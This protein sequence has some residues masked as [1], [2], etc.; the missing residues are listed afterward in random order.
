ML[1]RKKR[2][3]KSYEISQSVQSFLSPEYQQINVARL[4]HLQSLGFNFSGKNVLE[5]GAGIGDHTL[6]YLINNS[7]I[8][9]VEG[10]EELVDYISRRFNIDV[11]LQ[12]LE[13]DFVSKLKRPYLYDIAHCYGILYHLSDPEKFIRSV[14]TLANCLILETCVSLDG[15]EVNLVKE[16]RNESTQAINGTGCRPNR[17]WI[18]NKIME[19][20][21]YAY[22]PITQ[23]KHVQFPKIFKNVNQTSQAGSRNIRAI[24]I[25]SNSPVELKKLSENLVSEYHD[26]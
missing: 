21:E 11:V 25:G 17:K 18:F 8:T 5:L 20:F 3:K 14:A 15:D 1:F 19:N 10:R 22:M 7:I 6:F 23:P 24:F 2:K 16:N 26:W 12:D 4:Q 13:C 9:P